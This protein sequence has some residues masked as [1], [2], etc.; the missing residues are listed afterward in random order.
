MANLLSK[1]VIGA[2][3]ILDQ[4]DPSPFLGFGEVDA[5]ETFP[6]LYNNLL[7][8]PLFEHEIPSTDFLLCR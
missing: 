3:Y 1:S 6:T 2:P 7:R 4:G 8:A 5:G